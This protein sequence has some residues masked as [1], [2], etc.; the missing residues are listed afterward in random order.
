[1][2]YYEISLNFY[3]EANEFLI[4]FIEEEIESYL[5]QEIIE[6]NSQ[7]LL[8]ENYINQINCLIN[9]GKFQEAQNLNKKLVNIFL[10]CN[11]LQKLK[12]F[13]VQKFQNQTI[14]EF[15]DFNLESIDQETKKEKLD[16][17]IYSIYQGDYQE[18]YQYL[19]QALEF[20]KKFNQID[21][22]NEEVF[23]KNNEYY[24]QQL[25]NLSDIADTEQKIG[26]AFINKD[27]IEQGNEYVREGQII[28]N[29]FYKLQNHI[30][31][32]HVFQIQG[33]IS[34]KKGN[35]DECK[36]YFRKAKIIVENK[37]GLEHGEYAQCLFKY[38]IQLSLLKQYDD[39]LGQHYKAYKIKKAL[40]GPNHILCLISLQCLAVTLEFKGELQ[41]SLIFHF[42]DKQIECYNVIA[43]IYKKQNK[44]ELAIASFQKAYDLSLKRN[45]E[46][47]LNNANLLKDI[48]N[49]LINNSKADQALQYL[50]DS[51]KILQNLYEYSQDKQKQ[52][53]LS[54]AYLDYGYCLMIDKQFDLAI[55]NN[56]QA[57]KIM[58]RQ[59]DLPLDILIGTFKSLKLVF[60][61]MGNL[62]GQEYISYR[63]EFLN[64][65]EIH[66]GITEQL[67]FDAKNQ[68]D[69]QQIKEQIIDLLPRIEIK[70]NINEIL[71]GADIQKLIKQMQDMNFD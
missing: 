34:G 35:L 21:Y 5:Q 66:H 50:K 59:S 8:Q 23:Y 46:E 15:F 55:L 20:R 52:L 68:I 40:Y 51:L 48:G 19:K 18:A 56:Y 62:H 6:K 36:E 45:N 10:D 47:N 65:I 61:R 11:D 24:K 2:G 67:V 25:K 64:F 37:F 39:S 4:F 16:L 17:G 49:L 31:Q 22:K 13:D 70:P 60:A 58:Y 43:R 30:D 57:L 32:A 63:E 53:I 7:Q 69:K 1:M 3:I 54:N 42:K 41:D 38:A 29:L 71:L 9:L 44:L 27:E 33:E 28:L 12:T 26:Q 14:S